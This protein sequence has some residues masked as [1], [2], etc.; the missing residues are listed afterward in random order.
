MDFLF[1]CTRMHNAIETLILKLFIIN[2]LVH[3]V[4]FFIRI[5]DCLIFNLLTYFKWLYILFLCIILKLL[6]K[7]F[8]FFLNLKT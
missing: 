7:F 2:L 1:S 8:L 3:N 4:L 6:I 5:V